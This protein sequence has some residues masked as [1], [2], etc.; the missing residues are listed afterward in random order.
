[1]SAFTNFVSAAALFGTLAGLTGNPARGISPAGVASQRVPYAWA[2]DVSAGPGESSNADRRPSPVIVDVADCNGNGIP[3]PNDIASGTSQDCNSNGIPDEC[4]QGACCGPDHSCDATWP[5]D[6]S[7]LGGNWHGQGTTC[8]PNPCL[9]PSGA[10]CDSDGTCT[11]LTSDQCTSSGG[12]WL[13]ADSSCSPNPCPPPQEAACCLANGSCLLSTNISCTVAGGTWQ[14]P[15]I[16]CTPDPCPPPPLGACCHSTECADSTLQADCV[17]SYGVWQGPYTT[18][19]PNPCD[20]YGPGGCCLADGTCEIL[21][22]YECWDAGG[23]WGGVGVA[24]DNIYCPQP[25]ACCDPNGVCTVVHESNCGGEWQGPG[26][27]CDPSPC[28]PWGACCYANGTCNFVSGSACAGSGGAW[29]GTGVP[30]SPNPCPQPPSGACCRTTAVCA[31]IDQFQCNGQGGTWHGAGTYCESGGCPSLG[32]CCAAGGSCYIATESYCLGQNHQWQGPDAN[33]NSPVTCQPDCN[34]N[35]VPDSGDIAGGYSQDCNG[36][37]VPD[38]CDIT[39][40]TSQ[41]C[42]SNGIP[43]ECDT[44][45]VPTSQPIGFAIAA[46]ARLQDLDPNFPAGNVTL[47]GVPFSIPATGNNYWSSAATGG[48]AGRTFAMSF[49]QYGVTDVYTL[50]NTFWGQPGPTSYASLQFFGSGG[51]YYNVNLIGNQ[52]IRCYEQCAWT[53]FVSGSTTNVVQLGGH[54]LDMQ[55]IQLP[56]AFK[57]QTLTKIRLTDDGDVDSQRTFLA[58]VTISSLQSP[59]DSDHNGVPDECELG[60]CCEYSGFCTEATPTNCAGLSGTWQGIGSSCAEVVCVPTLGACCYLDGSCQQ[61]SPMTCEMS[62]GGMWLGPDSSCNA[63]SPPDCNE[64]GVDDPDDIASGT[65]LDCNNNGVPDECDIA[66][67]VGTILLL[68]D[69]VVGGDGTGSGTFGAGLN[70]RTGVL[71]PPSVFG[72]TGSGGPSF[73]ATNG[74][75][76]TANLPFVSGV[77]VPNGLTQIN[78]LGGKFPFPPTS[79]TSY[80]AIR[81]G[82]AL[83]DAAAGHAWPIRTAADPNTFPLG[84]GLPSNA[85][86]TFD[87]TA[88]RA[89][90]PGVLYGVFMVMPAINMEALAAGTTV[91]TWV[92]FDSQI[93]SHVVLDPNT[94]FTQISGPLPLGAFHYLTFATTDADGSAADHAVFE[95]GLLLLISVPDCNSNGVPDDCDIA[96]GYSADANSDGVPDECAPTGACCDANKSC[97]LLTVLDCSFTGGHWFGPASTCDPSP[98]VPPPT[99]ACCSMYGPCAVVTQATCAQPGGGTWLGPGTT[100]TANPCPQGAC[101]YSDNSCQLAN[102]YNCIVVTQGAYKGDGT[103]CDPNPCPPPPP[104]GACCAASG[105]CTETTQAAC[106]G[107]WQGSGTTCAPTNPCP[108]PTGACC[109]ANGGCQAL[110]SAACASSGGTYQGNATTCSP[111]PCPQPPLPTGA[112]CATDGTCQTLTSAACSAAGRTYAGDNTTCNPNPCAQPP[113][114]TGACCFASGTC[115]VQTATACAAAGGAYRGDNAACSPNPCPQPPPTGACCSSSH[116]CSVATQAACTNGG[117]TWHGAGSSCAGDADTDGIADVCDN[118]PSVANPDQADADSNG[119]GDACDPNQSGQTKPEPNQP[120]P[121]SAPLL[122]GLINLIAGQSGGNAFND[123]VNQLES[124]VDGVPGNTLP[125]PGQS[126]RPGT[127]DPNATLPEELELLGIQSGLCPAATAV[128]IFAALVGIRLTRRKRL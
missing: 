76:G 89:A 119:I 32:A 110:T 9:P 108:Q 48:S 125:P 98:C 4:E 121:P 113:P 59:I 45:G 86:V 33:C 99:G 81:N 69:I 52:D 30:C 97:R 2:F 10:C 34:S 6:C 68:G 80:D 101:C 60:A 40:G 38:E 93:R 85:G 36:N 24:C 107:T 17:A 70:P 64:N 14:G 111:N 62:D 11:S 31:D 35:G 7:V 118:C 128:T 29:Q 1:M 25:G 21:G 117:G 56:D 100:C 55:H 116:T 120:V 8:T 43:D 41:D 124:L 104:I 73:V 123:D 90:H 47:G 72:G 114:P 19:S 82:V 94:P 13:G 79:G 95:Y 77:F 109:Y 67:G 75:G 3:D 103:T 92:L 84:I 78:S 66:G 57:T 127:T 106:S 88:I 22:G 54:R 71:V 96:S 105:S 37:G 12:T 65:S 61:R 18:C 46:N 28:S 58:G 91:E 23:G 50:I 126:G 20:P 51:A 83:Y 5:L 27:T 42:N 16:A 26:T 74:T 15:G 102:A 115:Q 53:N 63:C 122:G 49:E 112:C 39:A 87:L 44:R